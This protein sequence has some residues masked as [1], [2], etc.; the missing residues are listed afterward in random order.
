MNE[1]I[2]ALEQHL[3]INRTDFKAWLELF[4]AY[5]KLYLE[6]AQAERPFSIIRN[7][8]ADLIATGH[9]SGIGGSVP[10]DWDGTIY[11]WNGK[12]IK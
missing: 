3:E 7:P 2:R 10:P 9:I 5:D 8:C 4:V 6:K 1:K 12:R 11:D